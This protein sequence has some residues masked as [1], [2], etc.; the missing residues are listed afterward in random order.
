MTGKELAAL[1]KKRG[2]SLNQ[3]G[4][5]LRA[6]V[7]RGSRAT[8]TKWE[9]LEE[10][11][12]DVAAFLRQLE[13]EEATVRNID[14]N[15]DAYEDPAGFLSSGGPEDSVPPAPPPPQGSGTAPL[16]PLPGHGQFDRVCEELWELVA[17]GVGMVGAVTGSENLTADGRIIHEDKKALGRAYGKLAETNETFR[18]MLTGITSGGAW[19]EV[20]LVSGITAGKIMRQHQHE[21]AAE[22]EPEPGEPSARIGTLTAV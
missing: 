3:M 16:L 2:W 5:L 12:T 21:P 8:V 20:A 10:V 18:K 6:G 13:L 14:P 11:P 17:T 9:L 19:L 22:P 15:L 1:R 7:G 4:E